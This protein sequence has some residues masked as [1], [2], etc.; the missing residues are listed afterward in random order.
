MINY[1]CRYAGRCIDKVIGWST[2]PNAYVGRM[3]DNEIG[4]L[5]TSGAY[6]GRMVDKELDDQI[7]QLFMLVR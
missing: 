3:I 5:I 6:D 7:F 1:S 2:T 4:W